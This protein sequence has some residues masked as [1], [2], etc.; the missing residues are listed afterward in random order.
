MAEEA[1]TSPELTLRGLRVFVA[2]E[3]AGSVIGAAARIGGSPSGVSQHITAL[4][5]AVGARLFDRKAKPVTLTPAG[6]VLRRHAHKLLAALSEAQ[7]DLAEISLASLPQLNLAI[8]DDLDASLT[9]VLVSALQSRMS[10]CFVHAF[11]GRSDHV[12]DRLMAREADI[13]VSAMVPPDT[14]A[15]RVLPILREP[16]VLVAGKGSVRGD[17]RA[18]LERLPFVQYSESLPIGQ[19]IARHLARVR[20]NPDR[21]FALEATR[22]VLAMV[23]QT[24]G[25]TIT[26][27]LNLMDA[28]RFLP[29]LE[30]MP[31]PFA[32]DVRRV[33]LIA[34]V[35][36]L[37]RLPEELARDCRALIRSRLV[38]R[39]DAIA[40]T[41]AGAI[42]VAEEE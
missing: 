41:L 1:K 38:P 23:V 24:G 4:E 33:H 37:G 39:F 25:W 31:L 42:E 19:R 32:G 6:Q 34:R 10:R 13:G 30:V 40:P 27:P 26:T 17:V 7:A 15:F 11:S 21:R 18:A 20:M 2:L 28:E 29:D 9:P 14:S 3:E 8:I 22:S 5:A 16:L 35:D 36:E 12:I